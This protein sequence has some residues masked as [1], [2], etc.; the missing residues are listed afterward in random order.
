[1]VLSLVLGVLW[2][3]PSAQNPQ[4]CSAGCKN[5]RWKPHIPQQSSRQGLS[6]APFTFFTPWLEEIRLRF[7]SFKVLGKHRIIHTVYSL[8]G[9]PR[10]LL[11]ATIHQT[12]ALVSGFPMNCLAS[13]SIAYLAHYT[14]HPTPA[15]TAIE[16]YLVL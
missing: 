6:N 3:Q 15:P 2:N 8:N 12:K 1:M 9:K 10:R 7:L 4:A 5:I 14:L 13:E 11:V 16:W